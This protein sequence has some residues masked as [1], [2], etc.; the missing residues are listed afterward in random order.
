MKITPCFGCRRLIVLQIIDKTIRNSKFKIWLQTG[1]ESQKGLD[2]K[3]D[4]LTDRWLQVTG[5]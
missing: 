5:G 2:T 1:H 3:T 4:W